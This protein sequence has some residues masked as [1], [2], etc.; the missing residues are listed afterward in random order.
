MAG[1]RTIVE[2]LPWYRCLRAIAIPPAPDHNAMNAVSTKQL[3]DRS[4]FL[5]TSTNTIYEW[6]QDSVAVVDGTTV[7]AA[8]DNGANPGRFLLLNTSGGSTIKDYAYGKSLEDQVALGVNTNL[9]FSQNG[10]MQG[11]IRS[12]GNPT[13]KWV[14][15]AGKV[16]ELLA[17]G[18][19]DNFSDGVTGQLSLRWVD[20][21][22]TPLNSG[23]VDSAQTFFRPYTG[24]G[25]RNGAAVVGPFLFLAPAGG[26]QRT[27]ALRCVGATGT[28]DKLGTSWSISIK[29]VG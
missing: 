17:S 27:I 4:R 9:D 16:Y 18:W 24:T 21:T 1:S 26:P 5:V 25:L 19:F 20:D 15:Q 7:I 28:A 2:G 3:V 6:N 8:L 13:A 14:L 29:E 22:D 11:I 10:L 23:A 12:P